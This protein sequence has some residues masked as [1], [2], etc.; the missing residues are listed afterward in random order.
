MLQAFTE[1]SASAHDFGCISLVNESILEHIST[2]VLFV[3]GDGILA[4]LNAKAEEMLH[5]TRE[6]VLG[7]RIDM[8]PLRTFVYRVLS[9]NSRDHAVKMNIDGRILAVHSRK[10]TTAEGDAAGEITELTDVTDEKYERQRREEFV[11]MMTHDLKGPLAVMLGNVQAIQLGMLGKVAR[12]LR[13]Q[14]QEIE[15]SGLNL[16]SMIDEVIDVYRL[17]RGLLPLERSRFSLRRLLERCRRAFLQDANV[18]CVTL[19]LTVE[20]RVGLVSLDARQMTRVFYNLLGNALK[21]T[22]AGGKV[23]ISVCRAESGAVV[24]FSDTGI[25]IPQQ[26]LTRIFTRYYR[27][28]NARCTEGSGLGLAICKAIVEAHGGEIEVSSREGQGSSFR[29]L[30]P[31][32]PA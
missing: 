17:D 13:G 27:S 15:K 7:K 8:L 32:D 12:P 4:F 18:K 16:R 19:S 25:G 3:D 22:N 30:L 26:D 11:A 21:F 2:G 24:T 28:G 31:L 5:V 10:V 29:V 6:D 1:N 14:L 9:E 23:E 20:N